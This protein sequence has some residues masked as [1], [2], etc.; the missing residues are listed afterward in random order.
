[1]TAVPTA[2]LTNDGP[3]CLLALIPTKEVPADE[4]QRFIER[5]HFV[6]NRETARARDSQVRW[7][8]ETNGVVTMTFLADDG[9]SELQLPPE[10][11]IHEWATMARAVGG[12]VGVLLLPTMEDTGISSIGHVIS[13]K[14]ASYWHLSAGFVEA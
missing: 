9:V 6:P 8:F 11:G 10:P 12:T 1:M 3:L 13:Q 14:D 7:S 2:T 5:F 4:I